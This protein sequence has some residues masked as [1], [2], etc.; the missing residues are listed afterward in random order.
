[1]YSIHNSERLKVERES[2]NEITQPTNKGWSINVET[3]EVVFPHEFNFA[4][5]FE[6]VWYTI[7][8]INI[9]FFSLPC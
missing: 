8:I 1:M 5:C 7:H 4:A 2:F 3:V 9:T 6:E